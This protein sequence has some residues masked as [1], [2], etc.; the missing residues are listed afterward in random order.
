[1]YR[2]GCG[3]DSVG[4]NA[5]VAFLEWF[6]V[7]QEVIIVLERPTPT[8]DLFDF[9]LKNDPLPEVLAKVKNIY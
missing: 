5:S 7:N 1:M 4:Q 6:T 3:P 2:A 8:E 9:C